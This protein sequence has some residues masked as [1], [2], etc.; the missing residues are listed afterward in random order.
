MAA[1]EEILSLDPSSVKLYF[2]GVGGISMYG[3]AELSLSLG[4]RVAG[5]DNHPS[6]RTE[7]L[8]HLGLTIYDKQTEE[9]IIAEAPQ[10]VIRT[11]AVPLDHPEIR[12][13]K[14]RQIPV[15]DRGQYLGWITRQYEHVINI[16]GTHG[17]TT[18]TAMTALILLADKL[19]PTVHIGA[20]LADFGHNTIYLSDNQKLFVSEAC[21]YANS[22]L[23]MR[24]TTACIL[25]IDFDHIDFFRNEEH[26]VASFAQFALQTDPGGTLV[27]PVTGKYREEFLNQLILGGAYDDKA[28]PRFLTFGLEGSGADVESRNL[29]YI[30][31]YPHFSVYVHG[32][33]F[34][35]IQLKIPGEHNVSNALAAIASC[36]SEGVSPEA[37][38][39]AL[40]A[41]RGADGRFS[42]K[43]HFQGALVVADYA[44]HP[45]ATVATLQAARRI[46][47]EHIW[48]VYQPLTYHRVKILFQDYIDA[49][50]PC[51][52][53]LFYEI[54]S[55]RE[56]DTLGMSSRHLAEALSAQ[57]GL[58]RFCESFEE[59]RSRLVELCHPGD[60][61]LFLGPE[62]VRSFADRLL[63]TEGGEPFPP[64][65]C[66]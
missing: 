2:V 4:Y 61:V 54:Y 24:S 33:P 6:E 17:K 27:L 62:Q 21:E 50:L 20:E 36:L 40:E 23:H 10:L 13:A 5:S 28:L 11:A 65:C 53:V 43:G 59:I 16:A 25:N 12:E 45:A 42:Q 57:G 52:E 66:R 38:K 1:F 3:L 30:E 35:E 44:H 22:F 32:E 60:I 9:N 29:E 64:D 58:G 15:I 46:P 26:L 39:H 63:A 51:E 47:H 55:D 18:T 37:C 56:R 49:L 31:G 34:T 19:K 41:Y 48:V 7:S 14:R 8:R